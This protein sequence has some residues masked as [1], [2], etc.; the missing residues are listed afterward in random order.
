MD[1]YR[2]YLEHQAS[3]LAVLGGREG[4]R[5][6]DARL[7]AA[8]QARM[9]R[10]PKRA[11][12]LCLGARTGGEVRAFRMCGC[13]AVGLDLEPGPGNPFVCYG[14][15]HAL[16]YLDACAD[17][18]YS[19]A[20][21]HALEPARFMAEAARVLAPRGLLILEI[22]RGTAHGWAPGAYEVYA[23]RDAREVV[24]LAKAASF[25]LVDSREIDVPWPGRQIT[26]RKG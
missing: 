19:N 5:E 26:F 1:D 17:V 21:D 7:C 16:A 24:G 10:L 18:V 23:Y 6:Y 20:L 4:L 11:R 25:R 9:P 22:T 14:D 13:F 8:L 15:F 3:K 2:A 12:V